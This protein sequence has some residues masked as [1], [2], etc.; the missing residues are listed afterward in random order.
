[1]P[2]AAA[3]PEG[4]D[5]APEGWT[6][7]NNVFVTA[8]PLVGAA[9]EQRFNWQG[10]TIWRRVGEPDVG[11]PLGPGQIDRKDPA[12]E[13]TPGGWRKSGGSLKDSLPPGLAKKIP[14]MMPSVTGGARLPPPLT[15]E[16]VGPAADR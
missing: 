12:L 14:D 7:T 11:R 10:N 6:V 4:E 13:R 1:M 5:A 3:P 16:K 8:G 2:Q 9:S 15:K